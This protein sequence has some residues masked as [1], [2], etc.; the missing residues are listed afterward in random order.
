MGSE[1]KYI[2]LTLSIF[3]LRAFLVR[4]QRLSNPPP[5]GFFSRD[6]LTISHQILF[7]RINSKEKR[8]YLN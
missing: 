3:G 4:L 7:R 6:F 8:F 1:N 2:N 5:D